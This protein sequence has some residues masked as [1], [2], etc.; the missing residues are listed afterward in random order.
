VKNSLR[1]L[2]HTLAAVALLATAAVARAQV[3]IQAPSNPSTRIEAGEVATFAFSVKNGGTDTT[4]AEA[5]V[6]L[7]AGWATV[8]SPAATVL[9]PGQR[10]VW[11][12]SA[13]SPITA[14]AG[15]Y[16][17]R[18]G[19]RRPRVA[20]GG[21]SADDAVSFDSVSVT[22]AE[23]RGVDVRG[24]T[25]LAYVMAGQS[26]ESR[27]I[28]KNLGNV[29]AR[30]DLTGNSTRGSSPRL[31]QQVVALAPGQS[32]TIVAAVTIPASE[33]S[34]ANE[35]LV[36]SATDV[37]ADSVHA[38]VSVSATVV[39][40][41]KI[42]PSMWTVPAQFALR[43]A[44]PGTGVSAF[45]ATG[46]GKLSQASDVLVDFDIRTATGRSPAF[47]EQETYRL[48]LNSKRGSLRLGDNSFGFSSLISNPGR[49]TGAEVRSQ[50]NGYVG[51]AYVRRD[52]M[53]NAPME[54]SGMV[55]TDPM[56]SMS[57]SLVGV[58]RGGALLMSTAGGA[59]VG[60]ARVGV[61]L[62]ASDSQQVTG[63]SGRVDINGSTSLLRYGVNAQHASSSFASAAQG[64]TEIRGAVTTQ[65]IGTMVLS[66][67][68]SLHSTGELARNP[69]VSQRN[70]DVT[71]GANW[72]NGLAVE[73]ERYVRDERNLNSSLQGAEQTLNLRGHQSRGS[74]D[75]SLMLR[76]GVASARDSVT[77]TVM[78]AN[79]SVGM[80]FS[81][82]QYISLFGDYGNG[83][84]LGEAEHSTFSGGA[85]ANVSFGATT[86]R[87]MNFLSSS[88][89]RWS[90]NADLTVEQAMQRATLALRAHRSAQSLGSSSNQ[91]FLEVKTPF[92]I[93]TTPMNEIGRARLEIVDAETGRGVSGTLV[94]LG[95]HVAVTDANGIATFRDL[96][97]GSHRTLIDGAAVAGRVVASNPEVVISAT[98]RKPA[99]ARITLARGV[100]ITARVRSFERAASL[101]ASGDTLTEVGAV[102]QVTVALIT[103]TD[104]L[105]QTTD[106]RGR[107]DFGSVPPG[108]YTVAIPRYE[109]PDHMRIE[110][111]GFAIDVTAGDSRQIE[112]RLL[113]QV[114]AVQFQ[115]EAT[116][117]AAP[118]THPKTGAQTNVI[119]GKP[120]TAPPA[121]MTA[122]P[123][124]QQPITGQPARGQ[125]Q[126]QG[127]RQNQQGQRNQNPQGDQR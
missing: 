24:V 116:I 113:P 109:A 92:G 30:F 85:T 75:G 122:Q 117:I 125:R 1:F 34:S 103:S 61:E 17:I 65:Q 100:R 123:N 3:S 26:Y 31:S 110:K 35:V 52:R 29:A 93:P 106:D 64:M 8:M 82:D 50:Y 7:P 108:H 18:A 88:N 101:L 43:S 87:V 9:A 23:R 72:L 99:E 10:E 79:G 40:A 86:V 119:T 4:T 70:V 98:S 5:V 124:T 114:R 36:L 94:R 97:P 14:A 104:T 20:A 62:A 39:P 44:A 38:E 73:A 47:G 58:A 66:A 77:R 2:S 6:A 111:D 90:T 68:S 127:Q 15:T 69:G 67:N 59:E 95:G 56:K 48:N 16:M 53:G 120:I 57:A 33:N 102:G 37:T 42:G 21:P 22:I 81:G 112:F 41:A 74:F 27:F 83:R 118:V 32:D 19:T 60:G 54:F 45:T 126:Q 71:I 78:S 51:G 13:R 105:W 63:T 46:A 25:S 96:Q 115:G 76:G 121:P 11:L 80:H 107:A 84:G 55:G 89:G 91:L 12:V 49:S 28:V